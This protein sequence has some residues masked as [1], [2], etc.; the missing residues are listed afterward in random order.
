MTT[1]LTARWR[2]AGSLSIE[3]DALEAPGP[4]EVQI[5]VGNAGICGS[6][7]HF[8]RGDFEPRVDLCP[9]HEIGGVVSAVG[10]GVRHVSDGDVVGVEPLLRCGFCQF[11]ISGDY[12]VCRSRRILG[13]NL[14]GGMA[15]FATMPGSAVHSVP[16][17]VD[18]ELAALAEPLAC[19]VHGLEKVGLRGRETVFVLG[20]GT[21][22]LMTVL[23]AKAQGANAVVLARHRHQAEA[24]HRVGADE[25]L[26]DDDAG[27]A[28]MAE[29]R[30]DDAIDVAVE[31]VGGTGDTILRSQTMVRPKG[32]VLVLGV[33]STRSVEIDPIQ[34]ALREI[35]LIGSVSYAHHEARSDY[36]VA[37]DLIADRSIEAKSL[38]THRFPLEQVNEAFV[39]ALDKTSRS[40]KVH[41][42]PQID[43]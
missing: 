12:H 22:G 18:T 23:A 2:G 25:V 13:E 8:H 30:A 41:I 26:I 20:A 27:R 36:A 17:G 4:G 35:E 39:A 33:F 40:I 16:N 42:R 6:D 43:P 14:N 15:R 3:T 29:L 34:L 31:A 1:N 7:L 21:L 9:G 32:R 38:V 5:A 24:A 19:A 10:P 28:R 11:C 37:L